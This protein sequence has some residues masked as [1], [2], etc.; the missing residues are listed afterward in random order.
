[1]FKF[2]HCPVDYSVVLLLGVVSLMV[3]STTGVPISPW[4]GGYQTGTTACYP[5][6]YA[7]TSYYTKTPKYYTTK[8]TSIITSFTLSRA[9]TTTTDELLRRPEVLF[10][11]ELHHQGNGHCYVC[12]PILLHRGSHVLLCSEL[13]YRSAQV[14][15]CLIYTTT[16]EAANYYAVLTY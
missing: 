9:T 15:L 5:T 6:T 7:A 8:A 12:C 16:I 3:E 2:I 11:P 1:M 4:C 14:L 13:L 10:C